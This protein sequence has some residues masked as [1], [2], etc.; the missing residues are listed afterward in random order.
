M[1]LGEKLSEWHFLL[2]NGIQR[3][4]RGWFIPVDLA[5]LVLAM[6]VS[7]GVIKECNSS[8]HLSWK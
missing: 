1:V 8:D 4:K 7:T 6:N 5:W 2:I 3:K